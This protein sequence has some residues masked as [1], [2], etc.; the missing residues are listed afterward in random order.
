MLNDDDFDCARQLQDDLLRGDDALMLAQGGDGMADMSCKRDVL[1]FSVQHIKAARTKLPAFAT[2]V[3][4]D[5]IIIQPMSLRR[6][7]HERKT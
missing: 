4:G 1:F 2:R 3:S 5:S 6:H 7:D